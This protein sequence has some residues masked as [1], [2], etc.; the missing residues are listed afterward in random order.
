MS[1]CDFIV[2]V[3]EFEFIFGTGCSRILKII[4]KLGVWR[5][6]TEYLSLHPSLGDLLATL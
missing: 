1:R 6:S 3:F 5:R 2:D 4:S